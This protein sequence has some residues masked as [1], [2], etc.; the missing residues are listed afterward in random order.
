[1]C[2]QKSTADDDANSAGTER[3]TTTNDALDA[4]YH[5]GVHSANERKECTKMDNYKYVD[6]DEI[7]GR[8]HAVT[9]EAHAI[10]DGIEQNYFSNNDANED[11]MSKIFVEYGKIGKLL[12]ASLDL[13]NVA[14]EENM[15][16]QLRS[17]E[18]IKEESV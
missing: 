6:P 16:W 10:I 4:L 2:Q 13:L 7:I 14:Q 12:R 8:M 5:M 15:K 9:E 18:Q 17:E 11:V 1:M 3:Q